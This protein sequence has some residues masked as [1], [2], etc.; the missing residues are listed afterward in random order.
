[1]TRTR[2]RYDRI[3][4]LLVALVLAAPV[5]R[6]VTGSAAQARPRLEAAR[7][8]VV[9]PGDTLWTL[10]TRYGHEG[11]DPRATIYAISKLNSIDGGRIFPGQT[12]RL[13]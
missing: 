6:A 10:A 12:L 7:V 8:V 9:R 2:V 3:V 4:A 11:S 5:A 13:P 1:M